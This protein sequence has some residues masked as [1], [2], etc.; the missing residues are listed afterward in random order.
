MKTIEQLAPTETDIL[1]SG[2]NYQSELTPILDELKGDFNQ[3]VINQIVLWKVNRFVSIDN[4]SL[5][6]LNQISRSDSELD[7]EL[8]K[9]ILIRLLSKDQKGVRLAMASTFLRFKN[10]SIYQIIDQ[11]VYRFIYGK[12]LKYSLIKIDQQVTLYLDYLVKLRE[13][14]NK[15]NVPFELADR[16]FYSMDKNYNTDVNLSGYG[17]WTTIL[18][19]GR[20]PLTEHSSVGQAISPTNRGCK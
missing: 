13:V 6:L 16:V 4:E 10:A 5:K 15:Q 17:S 18:R 11:R 3:D 20:F 19:G 14:C 2:Y 1:N 12:E 8:T 9:K 7:S